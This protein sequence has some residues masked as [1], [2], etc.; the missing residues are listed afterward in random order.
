[1]A[2]SWTNSDNLYIQFG[3]L[4][5]TNDLAGEYRTPG[6]RREIEATLDLAKITGS[7]AASPTILSN[8]L[9][10]PANVMIEEVQVLAQ[11]VG[12]VIGTVN[13]TFTLGLINASDRSTVV[14]ST[15]LLNAITYSV[16]LT[17][18]CLTVMRI[19]SSYAGAVVGLA[20]NASVPTN[21][22]G[23]W[24]TASAAGTI[25]LRVLYTAVQT[26]SS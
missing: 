24:T 18:G 17:Q 20:S 9:F 7:T 13:G 2:S 11:S 21:I 5:A 8:S 25:R 12:T 23:Y 1:M 4:K 10:I 22:T 6:D 3:A 15:G 14:S 16:G 26:I 19:G